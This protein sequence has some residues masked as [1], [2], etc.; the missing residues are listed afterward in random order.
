MCRRSTVG[1]YN[2]SFGYSFLINI[3]ISIIHVYTIHKFIVTIFG[4]LEDAQLT[5]SAPASS[6]I[7]YA[8]LMEYPAVNAPKCRRT[9][10][11]KV[12]I[13]A[14][15]ISQKNTPPAT[16]IAHKHTIKHNA[17]GRELFLR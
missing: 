13:S 9:K 11:E 7:Y 1:A 15:T 10:S 17:T 16:C 12:I 5:D 14:S 3:R 8:E 6:A 4:H 2:L